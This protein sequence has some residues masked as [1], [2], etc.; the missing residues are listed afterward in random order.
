MAEQTIVLG[1]ATIALNGPDDPF[2]DG[3]TTGYLEFYDERHRPLF[4]L[5]NHIV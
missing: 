3:Y 2:H 4:P 5:T 1:N